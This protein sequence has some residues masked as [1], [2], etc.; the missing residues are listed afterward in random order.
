M[1][2]TAMPTPTYE[3][4]ETITLTAHGGTTFID[5]WHFSFEEKL[6]PVEG[7]ELAAAII[8]ACEKVE[9]DA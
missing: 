2:L 5:G 3:N 4:F 1:K 8:G 7:R 6:T 9:Q